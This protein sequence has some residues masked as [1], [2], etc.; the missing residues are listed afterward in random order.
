MPTYTPALIILSYYCNREYDPLRVPHICSL[1]PA[2]RL[3]I[4]NYNTDCKVRESPRR[5]GLGAGLR[6]RSKRV[7]TPVALLHSL[8]DKY[9]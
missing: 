2:K 7:R 1:I 4:I 8:L 6:H 3:V 5:N 9:P